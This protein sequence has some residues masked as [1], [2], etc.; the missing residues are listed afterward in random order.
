MDMYHNTLFFRMS[1]SEKAIYFW[2]E[3]ETLIN[4]SVGGFFVLFVL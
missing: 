4:I 3:C 2:A 1:T